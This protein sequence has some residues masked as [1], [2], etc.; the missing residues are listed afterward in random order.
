MSHAP[1]SAE[2]LNCQTALAGPYC[3]ACGQKASAPNPTFHDLLHEF[4]HETL[5]VD[6]RIWRSIWLLLSRPG[7][8]TVEYCAGHKAR[9]L[10][11]LRLCLIFSIIS[12]ATSALPLWHPGNQQTTAPRTSTRQTAE[13]PAGKNDEMNFGKLSVSKRIT[14]NLSKQ[15][16]GDRIGHA[17]HDWLPRANLFLTPIWAWLAMLV[18]R[19]ARRGA[20]HN[21]P[22]YLYF[23]LHANAAFSAAF[24]VDNLI[25]LLPWPAADAV[26][27]FT[28][29]SYSACYTVIGL[30]TVYGGG[31]IR[32][33]LRTLTIAIL[34]GIIYL[35]AVGVLLIAA[36]LL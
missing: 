23:A 15:E 3:S 18:T 12:V 21:Y 22:E 13:S 14:G 1:V 10:A 4:L 29:M 6:G 28:W 35:V 8:I 19:K 5:H 16:V 26:G 33:V 20:T 27:D 32:N 36:V 2:C 9:F 25:D 7:R 30:R 31:W 34:Y 11:P 17:I 24:T